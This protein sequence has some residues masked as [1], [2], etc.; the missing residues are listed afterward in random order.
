MHNKIEL[1]RKAFKSKYAFWIITVAVVFIL[2]IFV[3]NFRF[4]ESLSFTEVSIENFTNSPGLKKT[5]ENTF[6]IIDSEDAYFEITDINVEVKNIFLDFS[7][8]PSS[9]FQKGYIP[10]RLSATD[11]AN[12]I[13]REFS[14]VNIVEGITESNYFRLYLSGKTEKIKISVDLPVGAEFC[15]SDI[16]LNASRPMC[17]H[18]LRILCFLLLIL[19]Y[20]V[21]RAKSPIYKSLLNFKDKY[22]KRLILSILGLNVAA[23]FI[24]SMAILPWRAWSN[25][26]WPADIEYEKLTDALLDGHFYLNEEPSETLKQ[27]DNPYDTQ[28]RD[29][30]HQESGETFLVDYAY[31]SGKYYCY[32]GIVPALL[33]FVPF[34]LLFG[35][36]LPTWM[37]VV[38]CTLLYCP[39][40]FIFIYSLL[41]KYFKKTSLGVYLILSS[42]FIAV[43]SIVYLAFFATVYSVPIILAL[44][45]GVLGLTFWIRAGGAKI[46]KIYLVLGSLCIALIIGCRPQLAIVLLFAFPI[47]WNEIKERK[48]FS[49]K[50]LGN[51]LC[52]IAPFVFVGLGVMYYNFARFGS[53]F[54][55]GA[56]Y[57][58]TGNDMTH[59]GFV[60]ARNW[61]GVFEYLFQPLNIASRFPFLQVI[62]NNLQMDYQGYVSYEP[63]FGGFLWINPICI[64]AIWGMRYF[65]K[66]KQKHVLGLCLSSF[67]SAAILILLTIQMSGLTQR[68]MS[69]FGWFMGIGTVLVL[70]FLNEYYYGE[71]RLHNFYLKTVIILAIITI[72]LNYFNIFI[73]ERYGSMISTNPRTLF[74]VKYVFF[75]I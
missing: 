51:T 73:L 8:T 28:L 40:S 27:M 12:A 31:F 74:W 59:R 18:P 33:F 44:L 25:T 37:M 45:F 65:G 23:I 26:D 58:L 48:F 15:V 46:K 1:I 11:E 43:S 57:N 14:Q 63:L 38:S 36:H 53:V 6:K 35:V 13:Y 5:G 4:W 70:A 67:A 32:F 7:E 20:R 50:G 75:T 56:N 9:G 3:F 72:F 68:Y 49:V 69:D 71:H 47:F 41:N 24:V 17:I 42:V 60:L 2:E 22:Q 34:K 61:L 19:L 30:L 54:D 55:F 29:R 10:L 52:V 39:V 62:G 64:A 21:F 66:L 16:T